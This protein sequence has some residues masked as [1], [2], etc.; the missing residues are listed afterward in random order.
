MKKVILPILVIIIALGLTFVIVKSRKTPKPQD[1][2]H[3]GPLVEV[4]ELKEI[5]RR[6]IVSATGTIQARHEVSITPQVRGKVSEVSPAMVAG[7]HFKK[8]EQLFA[9]EDVDYRLAIELAKA[10]LAQAELELQRIENL[11]KVAR[12]EWAA[13]NPDN[14]EEPEPLVIYEPQLKSAHAQRNAA[15]ANVKQ[16][17][18]NLQR[19]KIFAPFDGYVRSEQVEKDQYLNAG[20]PVATIVGTEQTEVVVPVPLDELVWLKIPAA[21]NTMNGSEAEILLNAGGK[22]FRWQGTVTRSMGEI[23]PRSRMARIVVTVTEPSSDRGKSILGGLQPG[24]FVNVQLYGEE[25]AGVIAV[26]RGAI[27]DNDTVWIVDE[28]NQ[29]RIRDVEIVRRAPDE[30]LVSAGI[31]AGER[32]I[33]TNLSAAADG[34]VLRPLSKEEATQ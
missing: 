4:T 16:A 28:A 26:P 27:H 13:L 10:S 3:L 21:E 1:K 23:D 19:T 5:S 33:L 9:I 7:G 34:M 15:E 2:P 14:N 22:S 8:G 32:I 31:K 20:A 12:R 24:M 29:L 11:A 25:V 30:V 6:I 18:I 17:E